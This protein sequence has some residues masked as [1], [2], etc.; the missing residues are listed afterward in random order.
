MHRASLTALLLTATL[1]ACASSTSS[2]DTADP[3]TDYVSEDAGIS[4]A[5]KGTWTYVYSTYFGPK[6]PGHCGNSGCHANTRSS[7]RCG[8]TQDDCYK[9]LLSS[10]L[11]DPAK[12]EAS[13]LANASTSPVIWFSTKGGMP[14]DNRKA[15]ATAAADIREWLAAG[16][17]N[18]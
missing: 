16:A 4:T 2:P 8:A 9:G 12:G 6:T 13:K 10:G 3:G 14:R 1:A 5:A 11:V 15:N 17:P 18:D 7:F